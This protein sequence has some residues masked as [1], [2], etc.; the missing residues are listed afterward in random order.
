ML[1]AS[2]AAAQDPSADWFPFEP[3]DDFT[4]PSAIG[5]ADWLDRPAGK[6]GFVQVRGDRLAFEDGTPVKFWGTNVCNTRVAW[7]SDRADRVA[8][9]LAKY[10]VNLVR[11]HKFTWPNGRGGIGD[12]ADSTRLDE[13]LARRWDYFV[14]GLAK[15][16]IYTGW[17]HIFGHRLS[18]ADRERV[19][20]YDEIMNANLPWDYLR[21]SSVG[22]VNFAPDLQDVNIALTVNML[23]RVNG[24][25]GRRYADDA[26]LAYIELQNEDDIFWGHTQT[27]LDRCPTYKKMVH[28]QFS[29]WLRKKYG[30]EEKLRAAWGQGALAEG[31][32]LEQG[33]V[34]ARAATA[35]PAPAERLLDNYQFLHDTQNLFYARFAKAIRGTGFKGAIVG[36]CWQAGSGVSH[37]YNL[38]SDS[39]T[40]LVDRHNYSGG[41]RAMVSAPG[42]GLLGT[43]MQ[44]VAGHPFGMSEWKSTWG[45]PWQA[46]APPI[47]AA[48]G[49][50]LQGWDLSCEFASDFDS[51]RNPMT[52]FGVDSPADMGQFPVLARM[53]Y[54]GDVKEGP[55][56]SARRVAAGD[57]ASG[58]LGFA[59]E[60]RQRGDVK[61][62]SG[63]VPSA[64]LAV[65]RVVVDFVDRPAATE[66][67]DLKR[68]LD[69]ERKIARSATGQLVWDYSGRGF[70]T[71]DTPGTQ[72][73]VGFVGDRE[74]K[75]TD[76][77]LVVET[78]FA[79][80]YV[81]SLDR[82]KPVAGA[83]SLL[84]LAVA[85]T[86]NTGMKAAEGKV[87]ERGKAPVLIEPVRATVRLRRNGRFQ[88]WALDHDGRK[89]PEAAALEVRNGEFQ[90]DGAKYRTLYYLVQMQG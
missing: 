12:P 38:R 43:G 15:R 7:A 80:V 40:G 87:V 63:T 70:F 26:C 33:T 45:N 46:E 6:H 83:D 18:P 78:P 23:N 76:V 19:A 24:A 41:T 55:L 25:T 68:W 69:A 82:R 74:H 48:Y 77:S 64:A 86:T 65:G 16:G 11:L 61:E 53:V 4:G 2:R 39:L 62:F 5:M 47:V 31:E 52:E 51:M 60:V 34:E 27:H 79:A 35:R 85:R 66:A 75:L 14:A 72:G 84:V 21:Q 59:D 42:S 37:Y 36:S 89:G 71:I 56:I 30:S 32:S 1:A 44:Q 8:D 90:I 13:T 29:E 49:L 81:A 67:P 73:V 57:L 22:L 9:R 58:R 88:V 28:R 54:R 17:S 20:A 3:Q 10:G 50:G